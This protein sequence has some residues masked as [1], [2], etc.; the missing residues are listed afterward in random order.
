M[1]T[2]RMLTFKYDAM[3]D[4]L[5]DAISLNALLSEFVGFVFG[6]WDVRLAFGTILHSALP[7]P[8]DPLPVCPP[9][10]LQGRTATSD[11]ST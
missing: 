11:P 5:S 9:G 10:M 7:M 1:A 2:A 8:F 6:R 3:F 4:D